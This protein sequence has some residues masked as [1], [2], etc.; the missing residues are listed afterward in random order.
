MPNL[1]ATGSND[2]NVIIIDF[3]RLLAKTDVEQNIDMKFY[4]DF[5]HKLVGHKERITGLSWSNRE[6]FNMLASCSYDATVQVWFNMLQF[7]VRDKGFI[8]HTF[9]LNTFKEFLKH[10]KNFII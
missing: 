9:G 5:K 8:I 7:K 3:E 6:D 2:F 10:L 1:I 4:A